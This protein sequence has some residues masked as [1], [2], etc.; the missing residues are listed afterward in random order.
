M[1]QKGSALGN[2]LLSAAA[3]TT[4]RRDVLVSIDQLPLVVSV[5]VAQLR[6]E[7]LQAEVVV[8]LPAGAIQRARKIPAN[9]KVL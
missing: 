3:W 7:A 2:L 9:K 4:A 5:P 1:R 6:E 8:E